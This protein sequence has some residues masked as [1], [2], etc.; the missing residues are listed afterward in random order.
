MTSRKLAPVSKLSVPL[1][2][3]R[4]TQRA[5]T[6]FKSEFFAWIFNQRVNSTSRRSNRKIRL[7]GL[8]LLCAAVAILAPHFYRHWGGPESNGVERAFAR[9]GSVSVT[10]SAIPQDQQLYPRDL[11]T[12]KAVVPVSGNVT[13][14]G[15]TQ[16]VLRIY[17][18]NVLRSTITRNL[19]YNG[20][21]ASFSFSPEINAELRNYK[22]ELYVEPDAAGTPVT[23]VT[24]VVAGDAY[25]INGQSNAVARMQSGVSGSANGNQSTYI[26]SFGRRVNSDTNTESRT[27]SN[28]AWHLAEG[29]ESTG[30]GAVGQWG[31]RLGFL[32]MDEFKVPIAIINGGQGGKEISFFQRNDADPNDTSTNYGRLLWRADQAGVTSA[33]RAIL[34]YQGESDTNDASG[35]ANGFAALHSDWQEDYPNISKIY[36]HQLRAGCNPLFPTPELRNAQRLFADTLAKVEIMSTTGIDEHD[37]CHFNY[38]DGYETIGEQIYNL[39]ARDF[40]GSSNLQ[41]IEP[42]NIDSAYFSDIANTELTLEMRDVDDTL[43]WDA[44][45]EADFVIEGSGVVVTSGT[46]STNK[47]ILTL[48]G[49]GTSATGITYRGHSGAGPWITNG[50][51]VGL[52]VF[53]NHPFH[54]DPPDAPIIATPIEE[55]NVVN[56]AEV[57]AVNVSGTGV[58][59]ASRV[60]VSFEDDTTTLI[61]MTV[62]ANANGS[63]QLLPVDLATLT[64]GPITIRATEIDILDQRGDVA[65]QLVQKDI[66]APNAPAFSSPAANILISENRPTLT[67]TAEANATVTLSDGADAVLCSIVAVDGNW[68]CAPPGPLADGLAEVRA[69]ATDGAGNSSPLAVHQFTVDTTAPDSPTI[70]APTDNALLNINLPTFAGVAEATADVTLRDNGGNV[71]CA[72]S[73]NIDGSWRCTIESPLPEGVLALTVTASDT[74]SNTSAPATRSVTIDT[75]PPAPPVVAAPENDAELTTETPAIS[76]TAE[77]LS[78]IALYDAEQQLLCSAIAD[79]NGRWSCTPL[80]LIE[81]NNLLTLTATD[82]AGNTSGQSLHSVTI[83]TERP[84]PPIISS[85]VHESATT[86]TQPT[87]RGT[88]DVGLSVKLLEG[89]GNEICTITVDT[90]GAWSCTFPAPL[91]DGQISLSAIATDHIGLQS[92]PTTHTFF[93]DTQ[94]PFAPSIASPTNRTTIDATM[95]TFTGSAEANTA[96]SIYTA[97]NKLLCRTA[98]NSI[99]SWGC[100]LSVPL[101]VGENRLMVVATDHAGN[102]SSATPHIVI[103]SDQGPV[104]T[105]HQVYL[106]IMM[107]TLT[108]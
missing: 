32:L 51:G 87:I 82:S 57:A 60:E 101:A 35:H 49:D 4:G 41:N 69:S 47:I 102:Q 74:V 81:G 53:Y 30:L 67:G 65:T 33:V 20:G 63:W 8:S 27:L 99:G 46:A 77:A 13:T 76:G 71:L 83:R 1:G 100:S 105:S 96:I 86:E 95:P 52:L 72:T 40:Y 59:T 70:L 29:D 54:L 84:A 64:D 34:W 68:S 17:R 90:D 98:A 75:L 94:A 2:W 104:P 39:V 26:R 18:N 25:V 107:H 22:F 48:S 78:N 44:G 61:S 106:P 21:S 56:A 80:P 88:A 62:D 58:A 42:P 12:N 31:L 73:A 16:A 15:Q 45:A 103:V 24:D 9:Q 92:T 89:I 91:P 37:G 19:T 55:D 50:N 6:T 93:V 38:T 5:V 43:F 14:P 23:T 108:N 97:N 79:S 3:I 36:V 10:F 85:P 28:T 7:M 11:A 66:F